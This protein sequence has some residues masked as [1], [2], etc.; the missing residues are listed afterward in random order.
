MYEMLHKTKRIE[1]INEIMIKANGL[2][3]FPREKSSNPVNTEGLPSNAE[4]SDSVKAA[5][6]EAL[7]DMKDLGIWHN[8]PLPAYLESMLSKEDEN[9]P[10]SPEDQ[11]S[12]EELSDEND[13]FIQ[14]LENLEVD[15]QNILHTVD[16]SLNLKNINFIQGE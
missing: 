15:A 8:G 5:R 12:Q 3:N 1:L 9:F 2:Y 10:I 13:L 7:E 4:I 16:G 11:I 14:Q 6:L